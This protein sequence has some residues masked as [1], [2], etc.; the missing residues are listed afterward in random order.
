[1]QVHKI[2][3]LLAALCLCCTLGAQEP[4]TSYKQ[5]MAQEKAF[6]PV[7][8]RYVDA[9]KTQGIKGLQSLAS[10]DFTLRWDKEART[11][12]RAFAELTKYLNDPPKGDPL[13][14]FA[15]KLRRIAFT[16]DRAVVQ[17]QETGTFRFLPDKEG[18][19]SRATF[20]CI[21]YWKQT[22]RK[23]P[24]GW[25]LAVWEQGTEKLPGPPSAITY[26]VSWKQKEPVIT[27]APS[28]ASDNKK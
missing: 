14:A 21:W 12:D 19:S 4:P 27:P 16:G 20:T 7:Y 3:V 23:T 8:G 6:F 1:M 25:R 22:W 10:P 13:D 15:V 18:E 24:H 2:G 5:E 11:G 28:G 9:I 17:T 26:T